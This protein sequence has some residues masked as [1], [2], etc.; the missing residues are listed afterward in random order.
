MAL[1]KIH[2][3]TFP[4]MVNTRPLREGEKLCVFKAPEGPLPQGLAAAKKKGGDDAAGGKPET[5]GRKR[6]QKVSGASRKKAKESDT[7]AKDVD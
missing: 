6:G 3:V 4:V 2:T 7:V 5:Q 1:A